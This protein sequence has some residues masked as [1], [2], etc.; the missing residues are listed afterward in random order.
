[1]R[2]FTVHLLSSMPQRLQ[3]YGQA[4]HAIVFHL[5]RCCEAQ[6][7][8]VAPAG[9]QHEIL[10]SKSLLPEQACIKNGKETRLGS[11]VDW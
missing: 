10:A 5:R 2:L 11:W 7:L 3:K 6:G 4:S 1:M 8:G 9:H